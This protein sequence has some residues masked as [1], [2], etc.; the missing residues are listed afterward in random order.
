MDG[1]VLPPTSEKLLAGRVRPRR[2]TARSGASGPPL[3]VLLISLFH[4][5]LIR[6][7]AQQACYELFRGLRQRPDIEPTLLASIDNSVPALFKS[8]ARITGFD[9][10]PGEFLFLS[11]DY[12]YTWHKATNPLLIESYVEFLELIRPDVVHFHHF[13]TLGVDLISIT[14]KTL[15]DARIV[16]T[17]HEFMAICA[18]DGQM[19]RR[20]DKSLCDEASSVRCHQCFPELAPEFF[21]LRE[22]WLKRHFEAVDAFTA[23][24]RFML[25]LYAK[26]GVDPAR[27]HH[28]SNGQADHSAGSAPDAPARSPQPLRLLRSDGRQQGHPRHPGG[29]RIPARASGFTDFVVEINGD[30]LRYASEARRE[31]IKAFLDREAA[32]PPQQ[33][34]VV[35]NGSYHVGQLASRMARVDWCLVP[36]VWWESF[37]LVISEAW[38]FKK[39]VIASNVGGMKERI[40][41]GVDGLLFSVGDARSLAETIRR[42]ATEDGLWGRLV[43]GIRPPMT[44]EQMTNRFCALYRQEFSRRTSRVRQ[45]ATAV[46]LHGPRR[47]RL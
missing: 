14:R 10:R 38:M 17:F 13:L 16:F 42:A 19:V 9:R 41:D 8:G 28:I 2:A 32:R 1:L 45:L 6:G 30:N 18:A 21:F 37:G 31:D 44:G 25:D 24:S 26:W 22:L 11:R 23:P 15:P 12:D 40:S 36:S 3:R 4:P 46:L 5:E 33:R 20:T 47:R 34:N 35:M 43:A 7:G 29:R 39:P 27:L